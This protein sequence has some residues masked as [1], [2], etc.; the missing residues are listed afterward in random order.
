MLQVIKMC[1]LVLG[2]KCQNT[3][4]WVDGWRM[5]YGCRSTFID[6][7]QQPTKKQHGTI[8]RQK[9]IIWNNRNKKQTQRETAF[10]K[11]KT[12][13]HCSHKDI[14]FSSSKPHSSEGL[15]KKMSQKELGREKKRKKLHWRT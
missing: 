11:W 13:E 10:D 9:Q 15:S 12:I 7:I 1:T 14:W 3:F 8:Q 4:N 2:I 6:C 5:E